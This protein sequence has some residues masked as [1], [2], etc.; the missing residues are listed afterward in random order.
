[1]PTVDYSTFPYYPS[2][3]C[4][5]VERMAYEHL[6]HVT[7]DAIL[8]IFE[9]SRRSGAEKSGFAGA[10]A[11]L[12][13][14][15]PSRSF[16]LDIDKRA[17]PPPYVA[18]N[19]TNPVAEAA[20]VAAETE[21]AAS[22]NAELSGLLQPSHGFANWRQLVSE[23]PNAI[24]VL[25]FTNPHAQVADI[26][27]Q[28][29]Q[30]ASGDQSIAVRVRQSLWQETCEVVA[31]VIS[32]L[33]SVRQLLVIFDCGQGRSRIN[34]KIQFISDAV[35]TIL[36]NVPLDQAAGIQ[37]VCMSNSYSMPS[38]DGLRE[39]VNCDWEIWRGARD[40]IAMGFGDYA[41]M[42]RE[43]TL[44]DFIPRSWRATV[45][46]SLDESWLIHRHENAGDPQGWVV[47]A[48]RIREHPDFSPSDSWC[49][50]LIVQASGGNISNV[51]SARFWHAAKVSGHIERQLF[52]ASE[53]LPDE[54]NEP[55]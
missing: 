1:M 21:A 22:F 15:I 54:G 41:A 23:F 13:G 24:P 18:Q 12:H 28:A 36:G 32:Q 7:K 9:L 27:T 16:I 39:T 5:D 53:M 52:H 11:M 29:A 34:D 48:Q 14:L 8:P 55:L 31:Q 10:I 47:G 46:H 25:Q 45:V 50:G 35:D 49:D 51:D 40:V 3:L 26:L 17:A 37:A 33:A 6:H 30:L 4:G 2:L 42:S 20:R 19:P 44:R 43:R 38:H